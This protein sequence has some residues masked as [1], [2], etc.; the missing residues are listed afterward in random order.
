M[1]ELLS[2]LQKA[3]WS[4]LFISLKTGIVATVICFFLGVFTAR[5]VLKAG[6][7]VRALADGILTLPMVLPPTASGFLLLR[8]RVLAP[9]SVRFREGHHRGGEGAKDPRADPRRL[10]RRHAADVRR[11]QAG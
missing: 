9:E 11:P 2:L 10:L 8:G 4:P 5:K 3:D 6:P 7:K 1:S